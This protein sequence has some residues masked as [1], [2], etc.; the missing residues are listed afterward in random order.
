METILSISHK[1]LDLLTA[2]AAVKQFRNLLWCEARSN[3][4]PLHK[5][6][7]SLDTT[8]S[9][10][11]IDAKVEGYPRADSLLLNGNCY[12]QIKTGKSFRPWQ[13]SSLKRELFG[14]TTVKPGVLD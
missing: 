9:D 1:V 2:E 8:V 13:I 6:V 14:K 4:L 5:I 10:G 12:F 11:G 3:G 7:V